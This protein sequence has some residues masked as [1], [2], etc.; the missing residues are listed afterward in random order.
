MLGERG[1]DLRQREEPPP[2]LRGRDGIRRLA[3]G[4]AQP[5]PDHPGEPRTDG[6]QLGERPVLA[7]H[8][9]G[10]ELPHPVRGQL[11]RYSDALARARRR[12]STATSR[13]VSRPPIPTTAY[14]A[15]EGP[16]RSGARGW[17]GAA[18]GGASGRPAAVRTSKRPRREATQPAAGPST[19]P[20]AGCPAAVNVH[21]WASE[22]N[23]AYG[24]RDWWIATVFE[25]PPGRSHVS[26]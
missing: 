9:G 8:V 18:A 20:H 3:A 10:L 4:R 7:H 16:A 14:Q 11:S 13:S 2:N 12:V 15:A 1:S 6:T 26:E 25:P 22:R 19:H 17:A 24:Y 23:R 21:T 5:G